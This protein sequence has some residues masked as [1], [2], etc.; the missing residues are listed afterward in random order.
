MPEYLRIQGREIPF[1]RGTVA[2]AECELDP[3]N[4][5]IQYLVGQRAQSVS[6]VELEELLWEKDAVKN[7]AA[8]VL[9]NGGVYDSIIVQRLGAKYRV[10]EGNSRTV[11]CRRL[12]VQ[13][14]ND[15]RF[16]TMPAMIFDVDLTEEDL[17]VLLADMHVAG[18]IRWDAYEQAKHVHDLHYI[19]GKT[20]DWLGNHLRLSKSKITE[21]LYAYGATTEFLAIHPEPDNVRKFS[22]FLELMKKKDL[23]D[24]F[25]TDPQF[26]QRFDRWLVEDRLTDSKQV[27]NL[28]LI[29]SSREAESALDAEGMVE[30]TRVLMAS[31]PSLESDLFRSIKDAT[32]KLHAA[33]VSDVQD[34][35][36]GNAQKIILLRNLHRAIEDLATLA[37][38]RL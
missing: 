23:R 10:R 36:S 33:P 27:R 16:L 17:A 19:Y 11:V 26:R 34:L 8:S 18:K 9:Q 4:P 21:L 14:P 13:Y 12:L 38:V 3:R 20:Y 32:L 2:V 1:E 28:P 37:E 31:D 25:N 29:L 5:R 6:E 22:I 35:K 15:R 30:A 7:L 24:R